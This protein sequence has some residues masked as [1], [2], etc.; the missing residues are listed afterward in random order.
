MK[1]SVMYFSNSLPFINFT[2]SKD[3]V[4]VR[5]LD[6]EDK[7]VVIDEDNGKIFPLFPP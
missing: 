6:C 4:E 3:W 7:E 5:T 2:F 1:A